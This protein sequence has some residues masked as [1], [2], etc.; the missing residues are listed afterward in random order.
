M[1]TGAFIFMYCTGSTCTANV[2]ARETTLFLL[3]LFVW[4]QKNKETLKQFYIE[5]QE[6]QR[7]KEVRAAVRRVMAQG[8]P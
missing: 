6:V 2:Q 5:K 1:F 4:L 8:F 7:K 3:F